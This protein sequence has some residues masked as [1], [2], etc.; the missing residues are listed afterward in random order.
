MFNPLSLKFLLSCTSVL[1]LA[2]FVAGLFSGCQ[3]TESS[4]QLAISDTSSEKNDFQE[5]LLESYAIDA[6][7][8]ELV[9]AEEFGPSVAFGKGDG[10]KSVPALC[11]SVIY[12]L[13]GGLLEIPPHLL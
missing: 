6:I 9:K 5:F 12:M 13:V 11:L 1:L 7:I 2:S 8:Y 4:M 10:A 3:N